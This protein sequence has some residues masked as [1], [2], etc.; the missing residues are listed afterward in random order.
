MMRGSAADQ[1]LLLDY[2]SKT[3]RQGQITGLSL[4]FIR[5]PAVATPA[6]PSGNDGNHI[7]STSVDR[8]LVNLFYVF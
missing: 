7:H 5:P 2:G 1:W 4:G 6:T 3:M 8:L